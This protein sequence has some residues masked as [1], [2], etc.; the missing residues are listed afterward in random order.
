MNAA[1]EAGIAIAR[2]RTFEEFRKELQYTEVLSRMSLINVEI[3]WRKRAD[4]F[5]E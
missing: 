3:D 5:H 2:V 1:A 4:P